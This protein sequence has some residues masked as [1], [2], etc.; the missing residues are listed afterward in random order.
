[1]LEVRGEVHIRNADFDA[2]NAARDLKGLRLFKSARNAAA[3]AMR[4]LERPAGDGTDAGPLRFLAYSWGEVRMA[5]MQSSSAAA[6]AGIASPENGGDDDLSLASGRQLSTSQPIS[7]DNGGS[8][9]PVAGGYQLSNTQFFSDDTGGGGGGSSLVQGRQL[10]TSQ[11]MN[12]D[13]GSS[14][15]RLVLYTKPGCCLCDGLKDTLEVLKLFVSYLAPPH[16]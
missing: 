6:T 8:D 5:A 2:A 13:N 9:L 16:S 10:S 15:H 7:D 1:V 4:R 3:G 14:G 11:P 12:D